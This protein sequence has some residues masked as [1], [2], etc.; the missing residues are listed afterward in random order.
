MCKVSLGHE[1]GGAILRHRLCLQLKSLE[2]KSPLED[3]GCADSC[4]ASGQKLC[5][6]KGCWGICS[7]SMQSM[8]GFKLHQCSSTNPGV[9]L[10]VW[11]VSTASTGINSAGKTGCAEFHW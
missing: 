7:L 11:S 9:Y 2:D 5:L 8:G 3:V 6:Q 1:G 10:P 4:S